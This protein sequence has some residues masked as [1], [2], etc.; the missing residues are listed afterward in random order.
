MLS[1]G[2]QC[3]IRR[4]ARTWSARAVAPEAMVEAMYAQGPALDCVISLDARDAVLLFAHPRAPNATG[5]R[6]ADDEKALRRQWRDRESRPAPGGEPGVPS[7]VRYRE[8]ISRTAGRIRQ[9]LRR[10]T[11]LGDAMAGRAIGQ[12]LPR[13][14]GSLATA[15]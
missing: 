12:R 5:S 10:V 9:T 2:T 7:S 14:L 1:T 11:G 13:R 4:T 15:A 3:T 8:F 6:M